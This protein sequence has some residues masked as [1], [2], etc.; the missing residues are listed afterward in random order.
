M[1]YSKELIDE[2][3]ELFPNSYDM[4]RHAE[5][6]SEM[7]GRYLDDSSSNSISVDKILEAKSLEEIQTLARKAKRKV[8][9]CRKWGQEWDAQRELTANRQN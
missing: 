7:L 4:L 9:L 6:G 3:K 2:V 5:A 8:E 1:K